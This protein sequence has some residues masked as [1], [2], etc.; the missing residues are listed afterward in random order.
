[1]TPVITLFHSLQ[2][3]LHYKI[4]T[5][6]TTKSKL[7]AKKK[8]IFLCICVVKQYF[9]CKKNDKNICL[10]P[11]QKNFRI[12]HRLKIYFFSRRDEKF[13]NNCLSFFPRA[14]CKKSSQQ[15][16]NFPLKYKT[17]FFIFHGCR[18]KIENLIVTLSN[19]CFVPSCINCIFKNVFAMLLLDISSVPN[20]K[21]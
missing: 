11:M 9:L 19:L 12:C 17:H 7:C 6:E 21:E 16:V 2:I 15:R 20:S 13:G 18:R 4:T 5:W 8:V 3:G 10:S 14:L 1:M